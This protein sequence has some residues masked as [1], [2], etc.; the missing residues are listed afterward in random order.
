MKHRRPI[1]GPR[2]LVHGLIWGCVLGLVGCK[3]AKTQ[4]AEAAKQKLML[5]VSQGRAAMGEG[6]YDT[7]IAAFKTAVAVR[8]QEGSNYLLLAEAYVAAE[9]PGLALL[10]LKEAEATGSADDK[11]LKRLRAD[12]F[13]RLREPKNAIGLLVALRDAD[14]LSDAETLKLA[15]LQARQ[16][17][18]DA[19]YK[20]IEKVQLRKPNDPYARVVEAQVLL[21]AGEETLAADMMDKVIAEHPGL[22]EARLLR[23]RYFLAN[24]LPENAELDL[25]QLGFEAAKRPDVLDLKAVALKRQEKYDEAVKLLDAAS[26]QGL[27]NA[28]VL[29]RLAEIRLLKGEADEAMVLVDRAL[30]LKPQHALSLWVRGRAAELKGNRRE[31]EENFNYAHRADPM[32]GQAL[33]SLAALALEKGDKAKALESLE[34][35]LSLNEAS[36]S[37]RMQLANIYVDTLINVPRA[38]KLATELLKEQPQNEEAKKVLS[39]IRGSGENRQ[40][41]GPVRIG[42]KRR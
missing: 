22:A 26:A 19:A 16:G 31:A 13:I 5:A 36:R 24:D 8:P 6:D 20:S 41:K 4:A 1:A 9:S 7:A 10:T 17:E 34:R 33:S 42:G 18:V 21:Q 11:R 37:E 23:A 2:L 12:V 29:A 3:D 39:R 32:F 14:Q 38:E 25:G 28:D 30:V 27:P 35:L 15:E 40:K